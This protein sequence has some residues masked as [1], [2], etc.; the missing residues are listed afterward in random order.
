MNASIYIVKF[1]A[2]VWVEGSDPM[3]EPI[4]PTWPYSAIVLNPRKS[5]L[6]PKEG[7]KL[8]AYL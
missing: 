3:A 2:P 1:I 6:V 4:L 7:G 5:S 8:N